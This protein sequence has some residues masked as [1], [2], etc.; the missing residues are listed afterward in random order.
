MEVVLKISTT[1]PCSMLDTLLMALRIVYRSRTGP[2]P[3]HHSG[4]H[5]RSSNFYSYGDNRSGDRSHTSQFSAYDHVGLN[6]SHPRFPQISIPRGL[7]G[8]ISIK[9]ILIVLIQACQHTLIKVFHHILITIC[10]LIF[11]QELYHT[12]FFCVHIALLLL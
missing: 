6:I 1:L 7:H 3:S 8:E 9:I 11:I 2:S 5:G 10:Y 4:D 12:K